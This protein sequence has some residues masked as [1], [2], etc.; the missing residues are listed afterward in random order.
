[1]PIYLPCEWD[2]SWQIDL[3]VS[4]ATVADYLQKF[5][6]VKAVILV[7]PNYFGAVSDISAMADLCHD[8]AIPLIIDSA[9]GSHLGFHPDLP[10]SPIACGADLVIQSHH[11]TLTALCQGA[12]L[13]CQGNLIDRVRVAQ[14]VRTLQSTSP[15]FL[16]LL[17]LDIARHQMQ[18][19]AGRALEQLGK[20]VRQLQARSPLRWFVP[21]VYD[22]TRITVSSGQITGFQADT[23][24]TKHMGVVCE[25]PTLRHLVFSLS[26]TSREQDLQKLE[27]AFHYMSTNWHQADPTPLLELWLDTPELVVSPRQAF[28][29]PKELVPIEQAVD[30]VSADTLCP[31]P[32]GIPVIAMG[33]RISPPAITYLQTIHGLGGVINGASDPQLQYLAVLK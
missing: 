18:D 23:L 11:K 33:E 32:P 9:H 1:M 31:Y 28:F 16:I 20:L 14:A 24:L 7:S 30:R 10:P 29:A 19:E 22:W 27:Q 5:P 26:L 17:S 6:A 21:P 8:R 3:G 12:V 15:S 13:H 25:M 2:R 4:P